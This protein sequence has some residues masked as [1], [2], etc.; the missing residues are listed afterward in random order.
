MGNYILYVKKMRTFALMAVFTV[1]ALA[2]NHA[3]PEEEPVLPCGP[4]GTENECHHEDNHEDDGPTN[5]AE[6][7]IEILNSIAEWTISEDTMKDEELR[8]MF[9]RARQMV[10]DVCWIVDEDDDMSDHEQHDHDAE[11]NADG[12]TDPTADTTTDPAD[13]ARREEDDHEGEHYDEDEI[14]EWE[15]A[16]MRTIRLVNQFD[17][18]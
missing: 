10:K 17:E 2:D 8:G 18:Y 12:A 15:A 4:P 7:I 11:P 1:A 3:A 16:C 6:V 14:G 5:S 13:E 9:E